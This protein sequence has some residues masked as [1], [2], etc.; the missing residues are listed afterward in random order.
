MEMMDK[1]DDYED[2]Y[3]EGYYTALDEGKN[4]RMYR[5]KYGLKMKRGI[6]NKSDFGIG[7]DGLNKQALRLHT[8]RT[9]AKIRDAVKSRY[10]KK[11]KSYDYRL[12]HKNDT[13]IWDPNGKL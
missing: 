4:S 13:A 11:I 5:E 12:K 9:N 7:S 10:N 8:R 2:A 6:P 1:D 3:L